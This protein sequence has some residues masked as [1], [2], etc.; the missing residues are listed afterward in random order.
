MSQLFHKQCFIIYYMECLFLCDD[1][2]RTGR[3][4]LYIDFHGVPI[5]G[6]PFEVLFVAGYPNSQATRIISPNEPSKCFASSLEIIDLP[7]PIELDQKRGDICEGIKQF[8]DTIKLLE[9]HGKKYE[10]EIVIRLYDS[11]GSPLSA[12]GHLVSAHGTGGTN[13]VSLMDFGTG[14]YGIVFTVSIPFE[15]EERNLFKPD[16]NILLDEKPIFGSPIHLEPQ[17]L[18]EI[19]SLYERIDELC[20][21]MSIENKVEKLLEL[22]NPIGA[23]RRIDINFQNDQQYL[24]NKLKELDVAAEQLRAID[25]SECVKCLSDMVE[26]N[27]DALEKDQLELTSEKAFKGLEQRWLT[28]QEFR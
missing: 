28:M 21:A 10:N 7:R 9:I 6:S 1:F 23:S 25:E 18:S 14:S 4:K 2:F 26:G 22:N 15:L 12:G 17:N 19:L 11:S 20:A 5:A 8:N 13:V 27:V 3:F 16:L 24:D